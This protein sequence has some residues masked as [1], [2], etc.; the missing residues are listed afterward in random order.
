MGL[1]SLMDPRLSLGS[2][3]KSLCSNPAATPP[4]RASA[5]A[6]VR[7]VRR[8]PP[9][10]TGTTPARAS[11]LP[12]TAVQSRS[13]ILTDSESTRVR[14]DQPP[15]AIQT[16]V[17]A[18]RASA[19]TPIAISAASN[20]PSTRTR[21]GTCFR[22]AGPQS[23]PG[24]LEPPQYGS[25]TPDHR[26]PATETG[27]S[28]AWAST[29]T[30]RPFNRSPR[31]TSSSRSLDNS[32]TQSLRNSPPGPTR[33]T[34]T[35]ATPTVRSPASPSLT[36]RNGVI[37]APSH[38]TTPVPSTVP[39]SLPIWT[40]RRPIARHLSPQRRESRRPSHPRAFRLAITRMAWSLPW[41]MVR[42][43]TRPPCRCSFGATH[44][45]ACHPPNSDPKVAPTWDSDLSS[46]RASCR[47]TELRTPSSPT[48]R[49]TLP[50]RVRAIGSVHCRRSMTG[51]S[52]LCWGRSGNRFGLGWSEAESESQFSTIADSGCPQRL[53]QWTS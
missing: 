48:A 10:A 26:P 7:P 32:P 4:A 8:T 49:T 36:E 33:T 2:G 13:P 16:L 28:S 5:R 18:A 11:V 25:T 38:R 50:I 22:P 42:F 53:S 24:R 17:L 9:N 40:I 19:C 35:P 31:T 29:Q 45:S 14:D 15:A 47:R 37:Q 43:I 34:T 3:F 52:S 39:I 6:P 12:A 23:T 30:P 44:R 41:L 20:S 1:R 51:L 21:D 27:R 46:R